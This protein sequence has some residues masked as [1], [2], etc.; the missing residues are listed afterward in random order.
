MESKDWDN[1]KFG[2]VFTR[3]Y[4]R[5]L[6]KSLKEGENIFPFKQHFPQVDQNTDFDNSRPT[7]SFTEWCWKKE[8]EC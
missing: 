7:K 4:L 2:N 8:F 6:K 3:I 1:G 5:Y